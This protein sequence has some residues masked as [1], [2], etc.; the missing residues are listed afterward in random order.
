[1]TD[2]LNPPSLLYKFCGYDA[3]KLILQNGTFRANPPESEN[4]PQECMPAGV[5]C[6]GAMSFVTNDKAIRDSIRNSLRHL[7]LPCDEA[8]VN[9][10]HQDILSDVSKGI[11]AARTPQEWRE[12]I[13]TNV[14]FVSFSEHANSEYMWKEYGENHGGARLTVNTSNIRNIFKVLYRPQP[15]VLNPDYPKNSSSLSN[16]VLDWLTRKI[17]NGRWENEAEWRIICPI[18]ERRFDSNNNA[19]TL[20]HFNPNALVEIQLGYNAPCDAEEAVQ[21]LLKKY[22][23]VEL[24]REER[25]TSP[26][27]NA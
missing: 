5:D 3:L 6:D 18:L 2:N 7:N 1:M 15:V 24:S 16:L 27:E 4:D 22:P 13:I 21:C 25:V 14:A 12:A 19:F 20:I 23:H 10:W 26:G 11:V 9:S 17:S 8:S